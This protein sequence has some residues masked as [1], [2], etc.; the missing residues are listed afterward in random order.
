MSQEI[1]FNVNLQFKLIEKEH[2]NILYCYENTNSYP[3]TSSKKVQSND[4]KGFSF[5]VDLVY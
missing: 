5:Y 4:C 1:Q 3:Y 2:L